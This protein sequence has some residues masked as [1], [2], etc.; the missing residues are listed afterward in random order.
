MIQKHLIL[1]IS[2]FI[3]FAVN[4]HAQDCSPAGNVAIFSN[5]EGGDL[6]IDVNQDIPD[7]KIG[8]ASYEPAEVSFTG[9]F[10]GNITEIVYAA[11]QPGQPGNNP[12]GGNPVAFVDAP[13]GA[14]VEILNTP[15][16]TLI[17]PDVEVFDGFFLP[18]GDNSGI[19][20]CSTCVNDEYQGGGNTAEQIIDF[21]LT[22]FGGEL[23]FL[24]TQYSCWCGTQDLN[25]PPTC[26]FEQTSEETV[27]IQATPS[28]SLCDGTI[29][30][31]AG[32]GYDSYSWIPNGENTQSITVSSPGLYT[33]Q[34]TSECGNANDEVF[35][36]ECTDDFVV[37]LE[38][39]VICD[40][41]PATILAEVIGG[42][43]PYSFEW[44]PDFGM[45]PGPY[46]QTFTETT[47]IEV[48]VTDATGQTVSA[49]AVITSEESPIIDLGPDQFLCL[50]VLFLDPVAANGPINWSSGQLGESIIVSST[51]TYSA[52]VTNLCGTATDEIEILECPE[53]LEVIL[54]GGSICPGET[55]DL[56]AEVIGGEAPYAFSWDGEFGDSP[57]PHTVNPAS[58]TG[59]NLTVTDAAGTSVS[60]S[61]EIEV[62]EE[63]LTIDLGPNQELCDGSIVLDA[64]NGDALTYGWSTGEFTPSIVVTEPGTYSVNVNGFCSVFTD[65]ITI[66]ECNGLLIQMTSDEAICQGEIT[67]IESS[68][69]GGEPPYQISWNPPISDSIG[70]IDVSP[71]FDQPYT[72]TVTDSEGESASESVFVS[73][74]STQLE[75]SL[76]DTAKLCP[77][78]SA[79]LDVETPDAISYQWSTGHDGPTLFATAE[80]E[81]SVEISTGCATASAT[82]VVEVARDYLN[83]IRD[84]NLVYCEDFLPLSIGL[85][86]NDDYNLIWSTAEV[87]DQ[88]AIE[89]GGIYRADFVSTCLD[90][91][92]TWNI[93]TQDCDC[94]IFIPNAFTP[95][96]DELNESFRPTINC[97]PK[98]YNLTIYNR[99]GTLVFE[100]NDPTEG[101]RG[102]S[103]DTDYFG[104]ISVYFWKL[105]M[106]PEFGRGFS[107]TIKKQGSITVIR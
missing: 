3:L 16:V 72:L 5:Y 71:E 81:Y 41:V 78:E 28:L 34:V 86:E 29:T 44:S 6:V 56:F 68:V 65:Q 32:P 21:F 38:D 95:N 89:E 76:P 103:P 12:C 66:V 57:G 97:E 49:S 64:T 30:L 50:D 9:A 37:I 24:K 35:I 70:S 20:G 67:S 45:G 80:G 1:T 85:S 10:I 73:V 48:T 55:F 26:C 25:Q 84:K 36:E 11:Y 90:T 92:I 82:T 42:E 101:W 23:L 19:T 87:G 62:L 79:R 105:E 83:L 91:T 51:G 58:T 47:T 77:G 17:S 53:E 14:S 52:T 100:S 54:N 94:E 93:E 59:Y 13:S 2:S 98:S 99:W 43:A 69:S 61:A 102:E 96:G 40:D 22:E 4:L 46:T 18:A 60:V 107:E 75:V 39:Q 7:L 88:I 63:D 8:I 31:D 27:F 33:V 74:L 106:E 15:P 104:G